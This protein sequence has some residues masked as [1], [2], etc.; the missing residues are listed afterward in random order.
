[1]KIYR[2]IGMCVEGSSMRWIQLDSLFGSYNLSHVLGIKD[3]IV[4]VV[5][6]DEDSFVIVDR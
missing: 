1:M 6:E 5:V 3:F 4:I 2:S